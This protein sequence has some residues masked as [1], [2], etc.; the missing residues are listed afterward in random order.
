MDI[1][2]FALV[3]P[4]SRVLEG[5]VRNF[6]LSPLE[7]MSYQYVD[8]FYTF[9]LY[10]HV[11][12]EKAL[13][14]LQ[15][16]LRQSPEPGPHKLDFDFGL[17]PLSSV[18]RLLRSLQYFPLALDAARRRTEG[19]IV[20]YI[21]ANLTGGDIGPAELNALFGTIM[22]CMESE[23][24]QALLAHFPLRQALAEQT[25]E[26]LLDVIWIV[27]GRARLANL[28]EQLLQ[29]VL[30]EDEAWDVCSGFLRR[31]AEKEPM[32]ASLRDRAI[33][34]CVLLA[35]RRGRWTGEGDLRAFQQGPVAAPMIIPSLN[36]WGTYIWALHQ[37]CIPPALR[38]ANFHAATVQ[39]LW[40]LYTT[41]ECEE[42][43][44]FFMN[45][46]PLLE[47][48]HPEFPWWQTIRHYHH[49]A[50]FIHKEVWASERAPLELVASHLPLSLD[51]LVNL[52]VS[53]AW[54]RSDDEKGER[55]GKAV[56]LS[57]LLRKL[58]NVLKKRLQGR[59]PTSPPERM[60]EN[61]LLRRFENPD[62]AVV[63]RVPLIIAG[64]IMIALEMILNKG[65]PSTDEVEAAEELFEFLR[66][67]VLKP[68]IL[69]VHGCARVVAQLLIYAPNLTRRMDL[70]P[71]CVRLLKENYRDGG[72]TLEQ[73]EGM[74]TLNKTET[75]GGTAD[76]CSIGPELRE[77]LQ[78]ELKRLPLRR[79][80]I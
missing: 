6:L 67:H 52:I 56:Y 4:Q 2:P 8:V 20:D 31:A 17:L 41:M 14:L 45:G 19:A 75:Q 77:E 46:I 3:R 39:G 30:G 40:R 1:H 62:D 53:S 24:V 55:E 22:Q 78:E 33:I 11:A 47:A 73:V 76:Q 27:C 7:R 44:N 74:L 51:D 42:V 70:E 48:S 15:R 35:V 26:E 21:R 59:P 69:D 25:P 29:E 79:K 49:E 64:Y 34:L 16:K 60:S 36:V 50:L 13:G 38:E 32:T 72:F 37:P 66:E 63:R 71:T 43:I 80:S 54:M 23:S 28:R 61:P 68:K 5:V 9:A 58:R 12:H 10:N 57:G 18:P 65:V